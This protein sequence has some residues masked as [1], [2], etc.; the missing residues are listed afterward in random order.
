MYTNPD[1]LVELEIKNM[2]RA[3]E[4]I[5]MCIP[6]IRKFDGKVVNKR[7]STALSEATGGEYIKLEKSTYRF[8]SWYSRD[9]HVSSTYGGCEYIMNSDYSLTDTVKDAINEAGRLNGASV[10]AAMERQ[11][12]DYEER[13]TQYTESVKTVEDA[14]KQIKELKNQISAILDSIPY[15][16]R[17]YYDVRR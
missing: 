11:I 4:L 9:R 14:K 16:V 13:I 1:K 17:E 12:K 6:V 3:I 8:L 7:L 10:V 5:K 15:V 2:Q